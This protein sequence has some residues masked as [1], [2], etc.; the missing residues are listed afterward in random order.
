MK[1]IIIT[2]ERFPE[3]LFKIIEKNSIKKIF[4]VCGNTIKEEQTYLLIKQLLSNYEVTEFSDFSPNPTYESVVAGVKLFQNE[5]SDFILALGGGSTLDVAKCIKL[6]ATMKN[7]DNYLNQPIL[8]NNIP[9]MAIPTTAGTGSEATHFA[10]I[11]YKGEKYSVSHWSSIPQY[12]VFLPSALRTLPL[13]QKKA[14]FFDALCHAIE[15]FWAINSTYESRTYSKEAIQLIIKYKDL[16]LENDRIGNEKLLLAAN[17]AGKAI[18][19]AKTTAGHAMC[20]KLTSLLGIPHGHAAAI[21][22]AKLWQYMENNINHCIDVR[23]RKYL[24][25]TFDEIAKSMYCIN[26]H[27]AIKY[28]QNM[29]VEYDLYPLKTNKKLDLVTLCNSVNIERLN[30]NPVLINQD[31]LKKLYEEILAME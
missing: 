23:G 31:D 7:T 24:Q 11:Y 25:N 19:I 26:S 28:F 2:E 15:S 5:K 29:L 14:T 12:V 18:N 13:Y 1:Q 9:F 30:N 22:V 10:V 6:F 17:T 8:E 27:E 21:C 4:F 16:Y 3:E 20:Y